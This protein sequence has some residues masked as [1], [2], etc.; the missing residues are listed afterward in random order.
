VRRARFAGLAGQ[1]VQGCTT[2]EIRVGR[3]RLGFRLETFD[4]RS[5]TLGLAYQ[6]FPIG[7]KQSQLEQT[8]PASPRVP[9]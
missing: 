7:D 2:E 1:R 3:Q 9:V 5:V 4:G 8:T 6:A